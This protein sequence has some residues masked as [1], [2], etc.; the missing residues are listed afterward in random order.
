M[1]SAM[2]L[3]ER[4]RIEAQ[5]ASALVKGYAAELGEERAV[6]VLARVIEELALAAGREAAASAG[7]SPAE[8]PLI[9]LAE[10]VSR[11]WCGG[12]ALDVTFHERAAETLRFS[13]TRCRY[14]EMYAELGIRDLG[15]HLSCRRDAAFARGLDPS[16]VMER[17]GTLMRG[18]PHCDFHFTRPRPASPSS[19]VPEPGP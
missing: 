19:P 17:S 15:F 9:R 8:P 4:R 5:L 14:A 11:V 7:P 3:I 1:T 12:G 10:I 16:I 6:A 18:A 13:V 2:P